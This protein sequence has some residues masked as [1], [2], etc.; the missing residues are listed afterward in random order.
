MNFGHVMVTGASGFVGKRLLRYLRH[1]STSVKV[2]S[3]NTIFGYETILCNL[4]YDAI[5]LFSLNG[6]DT[7]FHLAGIAHDFRDTSITES[8][9]YSVNVNATLRLAELSVRSGVKR[10]VYVSSVKA[11]GYDEEIGFPEGVYGTTKRAAEIKLLDLCRRSDMHLSIVRPSLVYGPGVK[12]NLALMRSA[13]QRGFFPPIPETRNRRSLIHVDD[14]VR[15]LFLLAQ[16]PRAHGRIFIATDGI[17]YSTRTIYEA[18]C[19]SVSVKVPNWSVPEWMFESLR[20][21]LPRFSH[22]LDKLFADEYFCSSKLKTLG[23]EPQ[24]YLTDSSAFDWT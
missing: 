9:Y 6:I 12:G 20:L 7:V 24:I 10:F 3:R 1:C 16:H 23:F 5:P 17:P 14:L 11:G 21:F 22:K 13:I 2:L 18:L 15:C 19:R 4:Q 8:L